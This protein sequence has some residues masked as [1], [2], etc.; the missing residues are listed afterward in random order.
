MGVRTT[1]DDDDA[2]NC[3]GIHQISSTIGKQ[4]NINIII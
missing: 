2:A 4:N 1:H 3:N